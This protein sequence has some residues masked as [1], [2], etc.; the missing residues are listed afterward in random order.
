[1][2][3]Y[4]YTPHISL[5]LKEPALALTPAIYLND[6]FEA[7]L[8]SKYKIDVESAYAKILNEENRER[9]L[10]RLREDLDNNGECYGI[11]SFTTRKG[12]PMMMSHYANNHR[13]GFLE[14]TISDEIKDGINNKF[15]LFNQRDSNHYNC[16]LIKYAGDNERGALYSAAT[17]FDLETSFFEKSDEWRI[18]EEIRYV[19]DFR[20]ADYFIMPIKYLLDYYVSRTDVI[21]DYTID[22]EYVRFIY[23]DYDENKFSLRPKKIKD[24]FIRVIKK[25]CIESFML[26][27]KNIVFSV[28]LSSENIIFS[29]MALERL[30]KNNVVFYP[31]IKIDPSVLT[32]VYLGARFNEEINYEGLS[33]FDNLKNN[34][35]S[36]ALSDIDFSLEYNKIET[37]ISI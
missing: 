25:E 19:A 29:M 17:R 21:V 31:M 4:K 8:T 7:K 15:N 12:S 20:R 2:K 14:F 22:K 6:P 11:V 13:G 30:V 27:E 23:Q 28:K 26:S 16:G 9:A 24:V 32:G 34:I 10:K 18:E 3:I 37:S 33:I 36:C 1:M 5:F 35:Y